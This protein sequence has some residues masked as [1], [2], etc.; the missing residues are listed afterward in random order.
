MENGEVVVFFF[1]TNK[2]SDMHLHRGGSVLDIILRSV[3]VASSM[4]SWFIIN[5]YLIQTLFIV[6]LIKFVGVFH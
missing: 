2:Q 1:T 5:V 4:L 6:H 3:R